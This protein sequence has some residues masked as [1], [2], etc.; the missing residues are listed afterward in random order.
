MSDPNIAAHVRACRRQLRWGHF[1]TG[2][3]DNLVRF[4]VE[5]N[6]RN[7]TPRDLRHRQQASDPGHELP[8]P[9]TDPEGRVSHTVPLP[10]VERYGNG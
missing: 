10:L 9:A 6:P 7:P 1:V 2:G 8:T 3:P 4:Y 5:E